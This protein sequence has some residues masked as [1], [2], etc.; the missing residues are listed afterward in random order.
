MNPCQFS[1][2]LNALANVL[3]NSLG[4]EELAFLSSALVQLGDTLVTIASH[5][6]LLEAENTNNHSC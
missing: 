6:A 1:V 2:S 5:K 3:G 4:T